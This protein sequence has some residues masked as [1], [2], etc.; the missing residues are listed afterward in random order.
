M[1]SHLTALD[2]PPQKYVLLTE[3]SFYIQD[4]SFIHCQLSKQDQSFQLGA[5]TWWSRKWG[6]CKFNLSSC[7]LTNPSY[8]VLMLWTWLPLDGH[9]KHL[10]F[11]SPIWDWIFYLCSTIT[12]SQHPRQWFPKPRITT[13]Q[14][15]WDAEQMTMSERPGW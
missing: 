12:L 8:F 1:L 3:T 6:D 14:G 9:C 2:S 11:Q 4:V 10:H 5:S 7:F 15:M 13:V